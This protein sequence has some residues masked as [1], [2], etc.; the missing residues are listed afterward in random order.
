MKAVE[1]SGIGDELWTLRLED[2]PHRPVGKVGMAM[3]PGIRDAV[4]EEPRIQLLIA[5]EPQSRREEALADE[6]DLVLD[7]P[8]LPAGGRRAGDGIDEVMPA[9]LQEAAIVEP[10]LAD[11]DRLH[12]RLHVVVDAARA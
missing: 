1:A 7:L 6:P 10:V 12:R 4:V 2:L 5:F 8:L 11:E 9:H 3:R